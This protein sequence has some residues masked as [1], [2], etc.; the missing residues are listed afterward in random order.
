MGPTLPKALPIARSVR[1]YFASGSGPSMGRL[2]GLKARRPVGFAPMAPGY[3]DPHLFSDG[4]GSRVYS[5]VQRNGADFSGYM[6]LG[7]R[8]SFAAQISSDG[9]GSPDNRHPTKQTTQ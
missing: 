7:G 5:G 3:V 4:A 9:S 8:G 2:P 1:V 6:M